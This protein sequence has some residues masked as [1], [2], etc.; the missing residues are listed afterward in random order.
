MNAKHIVKQL[1]PPIAVN[2]ARRLIRTRERE[3][4]EWE[5]V[6]EG[7]S[8]QESRIKGWNEQSIVETQRLRWPTFLR[9]I[10]GTGPLGIAHEAPTPTLGGWEAHN[11]LMS[12]AYVLTLAAR[13]QDGLTILDWGGGAGHYYV[14]TKALLPDLNLEYHCYDTPLLCQLGRELLPE[15]NFHDKMEEVFEKQYDLVLASSSLQ[16]FE[17]WSDILRG[18][19]GVAGRFLYV[20]RVPIVNR[21][22]SFVV[23]QRPYAYGYKT[24][25]LGWALN[26]QEFLDCTDHSGM[27]L[28]REFLIQERPFVQ[29]APEQW[30]SRGFLFRPRRVAE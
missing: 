4:P 19:A 14:I 3:Q 24:E 25:Y 18:L 10:E 13:K 15:G 1:L 8:K 21:V 23:V 5:Y 6:P 27:E 17:N 16:Y 26:R 30:E 9:T 28:L 7:W 29:G 12:Y 11:T 22:P 2:A 20:T